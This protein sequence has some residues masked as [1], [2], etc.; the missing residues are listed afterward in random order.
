MHDDMLRR[1]DAGGADRVDFMRPLLL[2]QESREQFSMPAQY[3][4]KDIPRIEG[5]EG[6]TGPTG[7][8]G[9][10]KEPFT[11]GFQPNTE[12]GELFAPA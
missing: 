4:F 6:P 9:P 12:G 11:G 2:D 8:T 10:A 3:M 7:P 5:K 1:G